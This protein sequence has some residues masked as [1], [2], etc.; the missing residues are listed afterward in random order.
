MLADQTGL[1]KQQIKQAMQKGALWY[2]RG[3][4]PQRLRRNKTIAEGHQL[5]LYFNQQVLSQQP[6]DAQLIDDR[7]SYSLWYK[8][9]G[10]YSQ[11]SKWGDHC[12]IARVAELALRRPAFIVHRLDRATSGFIIVG[13]SKGTT[14]KLAEL[15]QQHNINKQY[16][17]V[18]EGVLENQTTVTMDIDGR[19]ACSHITPLDH[20][21]T[22]PQSL[23]NVVIES[24][25]K[26]Q[27]RRHLHSI[28]H[29]IIGDRLHGN[30]DINSPDLQLFAYRLAF[31][32]PLT[33]QPLR[34]QLESSLLPTLPIIAP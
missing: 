30:G 33:Q 8:P 20:S 18:C 15:F 2:G 22:P 9:C 25:R 1:S 31:D 17:A 14:T 4:K 3:K 27:I 32:C 7:D 24:G 5:H 21:L 10:L 11:G 16:L 12:T 34:Y 19:S 6:E 28:G 23:V 26:H 13:H 29:P